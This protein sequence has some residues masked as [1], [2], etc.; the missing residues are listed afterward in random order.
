MVY[1]Q[2]LLLFSKLSESTEF[3]FS[4]N[5]CNYNGKTYHVGDEVQVGF[6]RMECE[7]DGYKVVGSF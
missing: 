4:E 3:Y 1:T 7:N 2:G 5:A 6:L